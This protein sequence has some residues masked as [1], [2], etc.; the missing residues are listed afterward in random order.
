MGLLDL[1]K[2]LAKLKQDELINLVGDLYKKN[3]AAREFLDFYVAPNEKEIFDK[4]HDK[5]YQA[6]FPK[7]GFGN[8]KLKEG[9]QA[10]S[11]FKKLVQSPDLVADLM[12]FYVETGVDFTNQFGDIDESFYSSLETTYLASLTLM[13]K[14]NLLEKFKYRTK[15]VVIDTNGIGWGFHDYLKDTYE[16]FYE[17]KK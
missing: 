6:F 1:K 4:Y 7:R 2:A 16:D 11:D 13:Q 5:V 15:S 9:K 12:L 10:I 14:E 3:K 8:A 17:D